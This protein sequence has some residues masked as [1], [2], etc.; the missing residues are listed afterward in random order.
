M[1]TTLSV[2]DAQALLADGKVTLVDVR[3]DNE[4]AAGHIPNAV[5]VPL[6]RIKADPKGTLTADPVLFVC[7]R[8]GRS[9]T[10]A[11]LADGLGLKEIY[12]LDGGTI[13]W[14]Q[15]GLPIEKPEAS[16]AQSED[17]ELPLDGLVAKNFRE[18]RAARG[19][20]LDQLAKMTGLSRQ[21]LGQI[22][23]GRAAPSVSMVWTAAR[24]FDVP[25]AALLAANNK[26]ETR[27]LPAAT[28]K[29]LV[30]PDG[31]YSSRALFPFGEQKTEFYELWLAPHAR[32]DADAHAPGT[33]ENLVVASGRLEV[34]VGGQRYELGKGDAIVF[35]ADSPHSYL[36]LSNEECVVH[37]VMT[38]ASHRAP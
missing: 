22:E 21:L 10:A 31:R 23:L 12:N 16:V 6:D 30:S 15:A 28:A 35:A 3:D 2:K 29:R 33:R 9:M 36:N 11:K 38:Y 19:L 13:G 14:A 37:L 4:W 17:E 1:I 24:A 5:H 7:A 25:F 34:S 8:G 32:E 20:T 18:L 26:V 27:V